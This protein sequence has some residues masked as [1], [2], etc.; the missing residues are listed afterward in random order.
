MPRDRTAKTHNKLSCPPDAAASEIHH[1]S[2]LSPGDTSFQELE[3]C[4]D[5]NGSILIF[6]DSKSAHLPQSTRSIFQKLS[7]WW[8]R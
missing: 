3:W 5:G 7:A 6:S 8:A 2:A 4:A 1:T